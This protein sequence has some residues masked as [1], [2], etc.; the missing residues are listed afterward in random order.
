MSR[1]MADDQGS[2]EK[3]FPCKLHRPGQGE[4]DEA[5]IRVMH[6]QKHGTAVLLEMLP[7]VFLDTRHL[8]EELEK[9]PL[10]R[11]FQIDLREM[12]E[13]EGEGENADPSTCNNAISS[14][15]LDGSCQIELSADA[16][17]ELRQRLT[18]P[19]SGSAA[20]PPTVRLQIPLSSI[21]PIKWYNK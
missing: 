5:S 13:G 6:S 18:P 1:E 21:S 2:T 9:R 10:M 7:P 15:S 16:V 4:A 3:Q 14:S 20:A 11:Q 12:E 8:R 19:S 17:K